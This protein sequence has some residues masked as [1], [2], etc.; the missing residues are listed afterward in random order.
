M[1][2]VVCSTIKSYIQKIL[3]CIQSY[4]PNVEMKQREY[5][6]NTHQHPDW[7]PGGE[8][9]NSSAS[10]HWHHPEPGGVCSGGTPKIAP[11]GFCYIHNF[12][13]C[14]HNSELYIDRNVSTVCLIFLSLKIQIQMLAN[15]KCQYS[16]PSMLLIPLFKKR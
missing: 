2:R 9:G 16:Q 11:Y 7:C 4:L 1:F 8:V 6:R 3:A 15:S 12:V 13:E 10:D 14:A 5:V